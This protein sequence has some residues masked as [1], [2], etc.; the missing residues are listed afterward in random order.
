MTIDPARFHPTG[1]GDTG[2][3]PV[4]VE[5]ATVHD[6]TITTCPLCGV[7]RIDTNVWYVLGETTDTCQGCWKPLGPQHVI[8][9]NCGGHITKAVER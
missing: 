8:C 2:D 3:E 9:D 4:V 1:G 6:V 7:G 5:S